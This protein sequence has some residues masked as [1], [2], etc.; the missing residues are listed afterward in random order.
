M[1][2]DKEKDIVKI[3]VMMYSKGHDKIP[4]EK[5]EELKKLYAYC[6]ARLE[7]CP[8]K[9]KKS[10]CSNCKIHCYEKNKRQQIKAVMKYSGPRMLF[11]HPILLIKHSMQR[12]S[13]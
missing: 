3:M 11:K 10:F 1:K 4:Y 7:R 5:N 8:Y 12:R 2:I 13:K 9:E 6:Q